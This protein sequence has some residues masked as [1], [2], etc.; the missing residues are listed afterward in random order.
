MNKLTDPNKDA[1]AT[2]LAPIM[3][4]YYS[5]SGEAVGVGPETHESLVQAAA[6]CR[7][8]LWVGEIGFEPE[9]TKT[10][11]ALAKLLRDRSMHPQDPAQPREKQTV[12]VFGDAL[13][14][15]IDSFDLRDPAPV[16]EKRP[17][18]EGEEEQ[19]AGEEEQEEG[20]EEEE[21][22]EFDEDMSSR[23]IRRIKKKANID[24]ITEL[25]S[26][27]DGFLLSLLSGRYFEE[28]DRVDQGKRVIID[29][30]DI[31]FSYLADI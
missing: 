1:E 16:K 24:Q 9:Y 31:D 29:P 21:E 22:D 19:E 11:L 17:R 3:E 25:H 6:A 8:L 10:E 23:E 12:A 26:R 13:I 28:L 7:H 27:D 4:G 20:E 2:T 14:R 5:P 18:D 15:L 30:D